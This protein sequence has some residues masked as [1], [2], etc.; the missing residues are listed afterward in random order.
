MIYYDLLWFIMIYYYDLLWFIVI[1]CDLLWFIMIYYDL[2]WFIMIYCDLL[3]FIMIYYD[4]LWFIMIYYDLLWFI[5]TICY[6]D[7]SQTL[8]W[9]KFFDWKMHPNPGLSPYQCRGFAK[10][11]LILIG[12]QEGNR[13]ASNTRINRHAVPSKYAIPSHSNLN[14]NNWNPWLFHGCSFLSHA[15]RKQRIAI[16]RALLRDPAAH[17]PVIGEEPS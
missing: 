6:I 5:V 9:R 2:L 17:V 4:L 7:V 15:P 1:Y 16:A 13:C 12:G 10:V 14:W 3:W 11:L 8:T